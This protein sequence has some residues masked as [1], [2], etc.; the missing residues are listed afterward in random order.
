MDSL[1][2]E[3]VIR[4]FDAFFIVHVISLKNLRQTVEFLEI[5]YAITVDHVTSL[6]W[7]LPL[8]ECPGTTLSIHPNR[9]VDG[10]VVGPLWRVHDAR[11]ND[12]HWGRHQRRAEATHE[13]RGHVTRHG[14]CHQLVM[15]DFLL[16]EVVG[17]QLGCVY[18]RVASHIG[19]QTWIYREA[20]L[21]IFHWLTCLS[22]FLN[23]LAPGKFKWKF[24]YVIFKQILVIDGW[25]ISC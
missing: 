16:D 8:V 23:L 6:G 25:G 2:K 7:N 5:W 15:Q 20:S 19:G 24:K 22:T 4:C 14:V 10:T 18:D 17:H 1:P 9:T 21:S 3:P 13:R 11:L 12:V